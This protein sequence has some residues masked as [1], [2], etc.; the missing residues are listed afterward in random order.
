LVLYIRCWEE[1]GERRLRITFNR[2]PYDGADVNFN[3]G[4]L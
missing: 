2:N 4:E 1:I 3:I